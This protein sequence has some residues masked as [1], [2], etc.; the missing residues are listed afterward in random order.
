MVLDTCKILYKVSTLSS[1]IMLVK[2]KI[3]KIMKMKVNNFNEDLK[4]IDLI[5]TKKKI[6]S[7]NTYFPVRFIR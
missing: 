2:G 7:F 6:W 5:Y 1:Y 4:D 3:L